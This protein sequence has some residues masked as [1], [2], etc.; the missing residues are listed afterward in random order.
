M[1]GEGE[2]DGKVSIAARKSSNRSGSGGKKGKSKSGKGK[3]SVASRG[4]MALKVGDGGQEG[5]RVDS[6][7]LCFEFH[8]WVYTQPGTRRVLKGIRYRPM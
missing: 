1:L 7:Y 5:P 2:D 3:K 4:S 6:G 8:R